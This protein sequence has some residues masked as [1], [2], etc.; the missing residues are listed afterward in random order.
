M[1]CIFC[2]DAAEMNMSWLFHPN[3]LDQLEKRTGGNFCGSC[4]A[5]VWERVSTVPSC[6]SSTCIRPPQN[7][8]TD[9]WKDAFCSGENPA[10]TCAREEYR[11]Y[12]NAKV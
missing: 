4:A 9:P 5:K 2:K 10:I 6:C 11:R 7:P 12:V 1:K 3:G 8:D